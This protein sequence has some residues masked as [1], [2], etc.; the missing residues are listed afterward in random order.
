MKSHQFEGLGTQKVSRKLTAVAFV[1]KLEGVWWLETF[2]AGNVFVSSLRTVQ[3]EK[4][5]MST[6]HQTQAERS[7][8]GQE[9]M[10][11]MLNG[12][13]PQ[14]SISGP[15]TADCRNW[16]TRWPPEQVQGANPPIILY[17]VRIFLDE[18]LYGVLVYYLAKIFVVETATK[19]RI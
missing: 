8:R 4:T 2:V 17:R 1:T 5:T 11:M 7:I 12:S 3:R 16:G 18:Q 9:S 13:E 6:V 14:C 15:G 19:W 10:R